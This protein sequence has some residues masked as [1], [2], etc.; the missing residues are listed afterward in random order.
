MTTHQDIIVIGAGISGLSLAHYAARA[1][2]QSLVLES[3]DRPGGTLSSHRFDDFW[4]ELGA[5]TCYNSYQSLLGLLDDCQLTGKLQGRAKAPFRLW[6]GQQVKSIP[7]QLGFIE[8]LLHAPR[9]LT[10]KKSGQTVASYYSRIVGRNNY[11][12]L[13]AHAFSAVPSQEADDFPAEMLFKKRARRKDVARSF[14]LEGGLQTITDTLAAQQGVQVLTGQRVSSLQRNGDLFQVDTAAGDRYTAP[15]LGLAVPP[16]VAADLLAAIAPQVT[17]PLRQIA[18]AE[19][20]SLGVVVEKDQLSMDAVAA[21]IATDDAFFSAVSRDIAPHG[22]YRGF[23]FHFKPDALDPDQ[24]RQRAGAVL[25]VEP[26]AFAEVAQRRNQ[27][28]SPRLG[29]ADLVAEIDAGLTGQPL[30]LSGNYFA[31]LS[32]EDCVQRSAAEW[33]RLLEKK[34]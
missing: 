20:D 10:E 17:R 11:R 7:S 5:H 29:H 23:T 18:L 8:L 16:P 24:Q 1:G 26:A 21:L 32:I 14:T 33:K 30:L 27:V 28:P 31:G 25:G 2:L 12:R 34:A 15:R 6:S 4:L 13:F 9:L 22:R 3:S 19:V